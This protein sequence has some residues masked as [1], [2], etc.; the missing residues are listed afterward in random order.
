MAA[1]TSIIISSTMMILLYTCCPLLVLISSVPYTTTY[2]Y[3]TITFK[4]QKIYTGLHTKA[5]YSEQLSIINV[6]SICKKGK[7]CLA[8]SC[9]VFSLVEFLEKAN[10]IIQQ[11][12]IKLLDQFIYTLM[13]KGVTLIQV[14]SVTKITNNSYDISDLV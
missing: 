13:I 1:A 10:Q 2:I 7:L 12:L 11:K 9:S 4:E 3:K 14:T 5:K 8:K 6:L